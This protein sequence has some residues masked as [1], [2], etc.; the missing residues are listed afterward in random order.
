MN[1]ENIDRQFS[2]HYKRLEEDLNQIKGFT[3][4]MLKLI[5]FNFTKLKNDIKNEASTNEEINFNR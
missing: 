2:K 1:N 5:S 3:P 4:A